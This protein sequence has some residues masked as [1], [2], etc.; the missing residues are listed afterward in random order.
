MESLIKEIV[1][2]EGVFSCYLIDREGEIVGYGG[3]SKLDVSVVSAMIA[4]ISKEL[5][6]Q[7]NIKDDFSITVLAGNQNL[8]IVTKKNFIMAVFSDTKIDTGK[9]KL[10]LLKGAK[11]ISEEL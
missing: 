11:A 8:F 3:K 4:S 1:A 6:T 5:S 2:I 10:E 7:M 9:I